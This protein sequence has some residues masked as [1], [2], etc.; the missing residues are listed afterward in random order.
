MLQAGMW[1]VPLTQTYTLACP[2]VVAY[3]V[4]A[5]VAVLDVASPTA[6]GGTGGA[7]WKCGRVILCGANFDQLET[8]V[9]GK[10]SS[11]TSLEW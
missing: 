1:E 9:Q 6:D 8:E 11:I 2:A 3:A 10:F 4:D 5:V 7:T